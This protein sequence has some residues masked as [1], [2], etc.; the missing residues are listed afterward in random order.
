MG[1]LWQK[2]QEIMG[3]GDRSVVQNPDTPILFVDDDPIIHGL[4]S[5]YLKD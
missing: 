1:K 5:K 3:K 2:R 4:V